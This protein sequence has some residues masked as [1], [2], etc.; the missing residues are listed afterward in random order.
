MKKALGRGLSA[1][2]PD[3]YMGLKN[4]GAV[5]VQE[6]HKGVT[7]LPIDAIHANAGQPRQYFSDN[8]LGELAQSI[9]EN[10]IVQPIIVKSL[11]DGSYEIICGERR[12]R[13]AC[14]LGLK[15]I[16]VVVRDVAEKNILE[17]ALIENIQRED[18]SPVEEAQAYLRLSEENGYTHEEIAQKVGKDR[19]TISNGIRLLK[20]PVDILDLIVGKKI[21]G[22]HARALLGISIEEDQRYVASKIIQE[23]LSVRQTEKLVQQKLYKKRHAKVVRVANSE[24]MDLENLIQAKLGSRVRIVSHNNKKGKLEITYTSLDELDR[25]L[26][27]IGV[28]RP[29]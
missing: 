1:L 7:E 27:R 17:L 4:D 15:K 3:T 6:L 25:V 9:Q 2:V 19:A 23:S 22:G 20:L 24:I 10:G 8:A 21:S 28:Y 29:A 18:L 11:L 16:P 14:K 5:A 13:A 26:E 12:Y